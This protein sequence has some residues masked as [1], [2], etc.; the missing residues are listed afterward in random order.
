MVHKLTIRPAIAALISRGQVEMAEVENFFPVTTD[1]SQALIPAWTNST[2]ARCI[3]YS[4]RKLKLAPASTDPWWTLYDN[5]LLVKSSICRPIGQAYANSLAGTL[6]AAMTAISIPP[7]SGE[8]GRVWSLAIEA[9][10]RLAAWPATP[11]VQN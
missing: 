8:L 6:T 4:L 10:K 11:P 3:D 2:L 1:E 9:Q 7:G 5:M